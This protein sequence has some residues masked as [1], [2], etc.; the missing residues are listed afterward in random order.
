MPAFNYKARDATGLEIHGNMEAQDRFALARDL[1]AQGNV[2]ISV[3]EARRSTPVF[4][5]VFNSI[6]NR[7]KIHDLITFAHN[8]ST[9][10][11]AGLSLSRALSILERQSENTLFK[12]A[13]HTLGEHVSRGEALSVGMS[14]FPRIFSPLFISM[15]RAGEGSGG[16]PQALEVVSAHLEKNYALQKKIKG[17]LT[18]PA[19]VLT[20]LIGVGVLMFIY[21]VPTLATTFRDL[22]VE[23][24]LSTRVVIWISDMLS[25]HFLVVAAIVLLIIGLTALFLRTPFGSRLSETVFLRLPIIGDLIKQSNS[26][27]TTRSLSSLLTAGVPMVE[28]LII[29]RDIVQNSHYREV[30]D[31][32]LVRVQK[33]TSLSVIFADHHTL[34]PLFVGEMTEVGEETGKL[35]DMLMNVATFYED[36][37][38]AV[39]KNMSSIV[40]PV[41]MVVV[42]AAVGFFAIAMIT[43]L[44]SLV[45]AM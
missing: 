14:K 22:H 44:Y 33:G 29:T 31:S 20:T 32:A 10:M 43:P 17:A 38:D 1:R 39:T 28:S 23:L 15:V 2:V 35:S 37:V 4:E 13:L 41:L 18:Y 7:V 36:E 34:Y 11:T 12:H 42:G 40:E 27:Y 19:V 30:M 25:Q 21:V 3:E 24:P 45:D 16:L 5:K 26:A 9:M 6:F 8:L